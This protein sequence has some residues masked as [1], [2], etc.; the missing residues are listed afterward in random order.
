MEL[1]LHK[2]L[3]ESDQWFLIIRLKFCNDLCLSNLTRSLIGVEMVVK[4][5]RWRESDVYYLEIVDNI[6]EMDVFVCKDGS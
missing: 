5:S 6:R 4:N 1:D 2:I 3:C